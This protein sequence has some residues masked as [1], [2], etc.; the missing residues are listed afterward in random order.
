[1][2]TVTFYIKPENGRKFT[3]E[4][5]GS[6]Y[7]MYQPSK[8]WMPRDRKGYILQC[9]TDADQLSEF[10]H[11]PCGLLRVQMKGPVLTYG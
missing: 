6:F 7:A 1:M 4:S 2:R 3:G 8:W 11:Q 9:T 10:M 5:N